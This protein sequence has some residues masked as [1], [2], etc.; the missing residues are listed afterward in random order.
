MTADLVAASDV[1]IYLYHFAVSSSVD[2]GADHGTHN[3]FPT[4]NKDIRDVSA[5]INEVAGS[6]HAYWTS[7]VTTGDPNQIK[8]RFPRRPV[9][10]VYEGNG[11]GKKVVFGEGNDEIAGG[12]KKGVAVKIEDD[13]FAR[14]EC[15]YWWNR[16][17]KFEV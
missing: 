2:K 4:Y 6:M 15:P 13:E 7:F 16:T 17:E 11:R 8:G 1:P 14:E 9:W 10:P 3:P 5:T 12:G